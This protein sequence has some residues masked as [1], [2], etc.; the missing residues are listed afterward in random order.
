M[1]W[2]PGADDG[3]PG[4]PGL[5]GLCV[6]CWITEYAS[7]ISTQAVTTAT[8]MRNRCLADTAPVLT[9]TIPSLLHASWRGSHGGGGTHDAR[10]EHFAQLVGWASEV[11]VWGVVTGETLYLYGER[12]TVK[13]RN[14]AIDP[15]VVIHLESGAD[16][17]IVR[18]VAPG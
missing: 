11:P 16:V 9:H 6:T 17:L 2:L 4:L 12:S 18:G 10:S 5:P 14:L 13:A 1:P 7:G 3:P 8:M 15:R